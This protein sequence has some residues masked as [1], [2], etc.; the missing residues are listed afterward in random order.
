[1]PSPKAHLYSACKHHAAH[2]YLPIA[3]ASS[4]RLLPSRD[5][6]AHDMYSTSAMFT[7][8]WYRVYFEIGGIDK[9]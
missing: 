8:Q 1:M 7:P 9:A 4:R 5:A 3:A 6:V 2:R